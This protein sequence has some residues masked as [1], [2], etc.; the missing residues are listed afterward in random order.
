ME[1]IKSL[2]K[3]RTI[4]N[5]GKNLPVD[6]KTVLDTISKVVE[7]TPDAFNMRSTRV[8]VALGEKQNLLWDT[9]YEAFEGKV[10]R[11]KIDSFKNAAG[12]VLY[13]YENNVVKGLQEKF[14]LYADNFPNWATQA[15]AM[16]QINVW[17]AL[18]SL[19][20]GAS[21]QHYNPVIDK[22]VKELFNLPETYVLIA[23]M[24]FGEILAP[25]SEKDVEDISKRVHIEK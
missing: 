1:F 23:Q 18:S 4:Y 14:A 8:V 16:A 20:I 6:E 19:G 2:E 7:L 15:S 25:A 13:F 21:L 10:A 12:T 17:T 24:P 3:R 22:K 11:E 5:L 9:I